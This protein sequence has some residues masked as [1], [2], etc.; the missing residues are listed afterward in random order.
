MLVPTIMNLYLKYYA[1]YL[2]ITRRI[3]NP[4]KYRDP[5]T[6]RHVMKESIL[7]L[8]LTHLAFLMPNWKYRKRPI[9]IALMTHPTQLSYGWYLWCMSSFILPNAITKIYRH[10]TMAPNGASTSTCSTFMNLMDQPHEI[11]ISSDVSAKFDSTYR[12]SDVS[13]RDTRPNPFC[14]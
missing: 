12:T 7:S 1:M 5:Y 8:P 2:E 9:S 13:Y 14:E 3:G 6:E 11:R 10:P 4:R